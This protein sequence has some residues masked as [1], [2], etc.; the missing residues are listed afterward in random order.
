MAKKNSKLAS[1]DARK[2]LKGVRIDIKENVDKY[3]R[4]R[5]ILVY[6]GYDFLENILVVRTYIQKHYDI[7][8][9]ALELLLKLMGMRLFTIKDYTSLPK[10]F[11]YVRFN[12]AI[13]RGFIQIVQ[14][15]HSVA[16]Q[17][18]CLS[19][20]AQNICTNF[21][22]MLAGEKPIPEDGATNPMAKKSTQTAYDKKKLDLIKKLNQLPPKEHF[23]KL[24]E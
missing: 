1:K 6:K 17:V 22:Q 21:Y 5:F 13:D 15:E 14:T 3:S 23:K 4:S 20:R 7:D 11:S 2:N 9:D 8:F 19:A 10:K 16:N 18:Y 12:N 24:Y